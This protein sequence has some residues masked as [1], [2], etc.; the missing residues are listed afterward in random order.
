MGKYLV[1][2]EVD[3][4]KI[5]LDPKQRGEG[6]SFL[7]AMIRQDIEKGITKDWG[8]FVGESKGY[9]VNEGTELEVMKALQQYVPF[10]IFSVHPI[11]TESQVNEMIKGL[12]G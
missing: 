5:P 11:S 1:L 10:C 9:A 6:W 7:M 3:Q 8:S 2:W 4:T 12:T